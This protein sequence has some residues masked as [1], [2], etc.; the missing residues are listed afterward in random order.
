MTEA[1][2]EAQDEPW[3]AALTQIPALGQDVLD[4]VL[5][6]GLPLPDG[7]VLEFGVSLAGR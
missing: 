5:T 7:L 3:V 2:A 1:I 6:R 4:F